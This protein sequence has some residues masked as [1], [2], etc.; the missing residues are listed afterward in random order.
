MEKKLQS[1]SSF[2][3]FSIIF[4]LAND[5]YR[6]IDSVQKV[7]GIP[8]YSLVLPVLLIAL[9]LRLKFEHFL[10]RTTVRFLQC[11]FL[12]G[13]IGVGV[14]GVGV[15][16]GTIG[17]G[18]GMISEI[19]ASDGVRFFTAKNP[20]SVERQK[21]AIRGSTFT[22]LFYPTTLVPSGRWRH[23]QR[24]ACRDRLGCSS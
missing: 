21:T 10:P 11:I 7:I 4:L 18:R 22:V 6:G 16:V 24:V 1:I 2:I 20:A 14:G 13:L 23:R 15:G 5:S 9:V 19:T 8:A 3:I 17:Q 12:F